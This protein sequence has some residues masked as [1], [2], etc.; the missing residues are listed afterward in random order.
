MI[1]LTIHGWND[2]LHQLKRSHYE[3]EQHCNLYFY[4]IEY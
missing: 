2:K 3:K 4:V 1:D